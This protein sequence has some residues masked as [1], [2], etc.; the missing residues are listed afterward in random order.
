MSR[1]GKGWSITLAGALLLAGP[2]A[3]AARASGPIGPPGG[4]PAWAPLPSQSPRQFY[5][6][7][8]GKPPSTYR[9][10]GR[11]GYAW[12]GTSPGLVGAPAYDRGELI[13]DD[14]PFDD[15][16]A[17]TSS[18]NASTYGPAY[19]AATLP[20]LCPTNGGST[21]YPSTS[22]YGGYFY[23]DASDRQNVADLVEV[24]LAADESSYRVAF[25]LQS[26]T[27]DAAEKPVVG[28]GI[29]L[30]G[31]RRR[32]GATGLAAFPHRL[33]V[34]PAGATLDGRTVASSVDVT[35][36]TIEARIPATALQPGG[37]RVAAAAGVWDAGAKS[38]GA[39]TDLAYVPDEPRA[40]V[41][42][43]WF[44]RQQSADIAAG[45]YPTFA[46]DTSALRAGRTSAPAVAKGPQLRT[47]YP[48]IH[49]GEGIVGLQ[50]YAQ[51][52]TALVY[53]GLVEPYTVYVPPTYDPS[54]AAPV[55][56]ALHCL[57]CNH[58][59]YDSSSW[60]GLKRL[61]DGRG[62][63]IVTPLA[64]GEGGHYEGEAEWDVFGVLAD[65]S[66][67]YR[68]DRDRLYLS[69][70]SMGSLGTFRLG[71]LYPD[72]WA[73]TFGIG[74]YTQPNCVTPLA[75]PQT[76][77]Y[78]AFDYYDVLGNAR[79]LPWGLVNGAADELT[80]VSESV[81]IAQHLS[82][83]GYGYRLWLYP[84]RDHDPSLMGSTSDVTSAWL[85]DARRV[86]HPA[87]V[88]FTRVAAMDDTAAAAADGPGGP[89]WHIPHDRAYWLS[90]ITLP[91]GA[92]SGTV[93]AVSGRGQ[94]YSVAAGNGSG[95][96]DAGSYVW[97]GQDPA[98]T[99][100]HGPNTLA[101]NLTSISA[102]TIDPAGALLSTSSPLTV[103]V[104]SDHEATVT[105]VGI[106]T[107]HVMPGQST[108][109]LR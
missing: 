92:S 2:A 32:A 7:S 23:P 14:S 11:L 84:T 22:H 98:W 103:S 38:W 43:C 50:R 4:D 3:V 75:S 25:V 62:A 37:W 97:K 58:D 69:G 44:E 109:T 70:M 105:I 64:Y 95:S 89:A 13:L 31:E 78:A 67:R 42:N 61:A 60:P 40:G 107:I 39:V 106:G 100:V 45:N 12:R 29:Q 104:T 93:D 49:I 102:L 20:G 85:G 59:V 55:V 15:T 24:R 41:P 51:S 8:L 90:G 71:L 21:S 54:R 65:V 99:T 52:S 68:V 81:Q 74:N 108:H 56:L 101:L 6:S 79:N 47:Y 18:L 96:D 83:L 48:P 94:T 57:T 28:L 80:P 72:L 53:R 19:A 17:A 73:R 82:D 63:L 87:H 9:L 1:W 66:A 27:A 91:A 36:N 76:C 30:P 77:S 10:T 5:E 34:T 35:A 26:M 46:V 33:D 88:T 16:G 86:T